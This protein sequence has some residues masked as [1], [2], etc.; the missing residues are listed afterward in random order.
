MRRK[1]SAAL[2]PFPLPDS[3]PLSPR[4]CR[5]EIYRADICHT[6]PAIHLHFPGTCI[7]ILPT[8][9]PFAP[10]S[11]PQK[12]NPQTHS[13]CEEERT[14][15][16]TPDSQLL[17]CSTRIF[18]FQEFCVAFFSLFSRRPRLYFQGFVSFICINFHFSL[19][20]RGSTSSFMGSANFMQFQSIRFT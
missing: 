13:P 1:C 15:E 2:P 9:F 14:L 18:S 8:E 17:L 19:R 12:K 11:I 10:V 7:N 20:E 6:V 3:H 4:H 16:H 5:P